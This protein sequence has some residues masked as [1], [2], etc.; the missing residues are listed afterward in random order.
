MALLVQKEY[1]TLYTRHKNLEIIPKLAPLWQPFR[2]KSL[3]GGRG[4]GKTRSIARVLV[5]QANSRRMLIL[6][7]RHLQKSI[8]KSSYRVI[9]DEILRQRFPG[10]VFK[11]R[12]IENTINGSLFT[13]DDGLRDV[14]SALDMKSY[15]GYT[16][17][18]VAEAQ[19]IGEEVIEI[20]TPTFR[21]EDSEIWFDYNRYDEFDPVHKK[22]ALQSRP[23][24]F[25]IEVNW[26]DNPWFP[27]VLENERLVDIAEAQR[28]NDWDLY[29]HK[30]NNH[31]VSA[32][33]KSIIPQDLVMAAARRQVEAIEGAR[34]IIGVDVARF[35]SDRTKVYEC[36]GNVIK[37]LFERRHEEPIETAREVA[38]SAQN[39]AVQI[40]VDAGGLGGGGMIGKLKELGFFNVVEVNFGGSPKNR[41]LYKDTITE[42]YFEAKDKLARVSLPDITELHQD[43][44]GRRF[45][46]MNDELLRRRV[47]EKEEF[48]KRYGRSPD[49]GDACLLCLYEPGGFTYSEDVA[50][51]MAERR[52]REG[53]RR[54]GQFLQ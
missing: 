2:I 7:T 1:L 41:R 16:V 42:M 30:W 52:K 12:S 35:G 3:T 46:Y 10:W 53:K 9:K 11:K 8:E 45:K 49:D 26:H 21:E 18:W 6:C 25:F 20:L 17:C 38:A 43:L 29:N 37:R 48:K 33:E 47:E 19:L 51:A 23:D 15:E 4:S 39:K 31:P 34:Q 50:K 24:V 54:S 13:F 27:R 36:R 5:N 28:L 14:K 44:Y 22:Y 40:N 32:L